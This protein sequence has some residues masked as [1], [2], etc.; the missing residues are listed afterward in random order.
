MQQKVRANFPSHW[1]RR[2]A[3]WRWEKTGGLGLVSRGCQ[4]L[5]PLLTSS[6][7]LSFQNTTHPIGQ[8]KE[9]KALKVSISTLQGFKIMNISVPPDDQNLQIQMKAFLKGSE[10]WETISNNAHT[11]KHSAFSSSRESLELSQ[12]PHK[13]VCLVTSQSHCVLGLAGGDLTRLPASLTSHLILQNELF[14]VLF[15]IK[16]GRCSSLN[17]HKVCATCVTST[18]KDRIPKVFSA[19]ADYCPGGTALPGKGSAEPQRCHLTEFVVLPWQLLAVVQ[20]PLLRSPT[21]P[22]LCL[23]VTNP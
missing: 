12:E 22:T 10:L 9:R 15:P 6:S 18:H 14:L 19:A 20:S 8:R 21:A 13:K 5:W 4:T 7:C 17:I 3:L 11:S 16:G 23:P 2:S 1:Q